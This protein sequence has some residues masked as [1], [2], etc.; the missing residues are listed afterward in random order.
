[1]KRYVE[2]LDSANLFG[3]KI[4][5]IKKKTTELYYILDKLETNRST[6]QT[7][8]NVTVYVLK[9]NKV[10][11]SSF[12]IYPYMDNREIKRKIETNMLNASF[13]LNEYYAIEKN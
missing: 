11:A 12:D 1:M 13:A 7:L 2:L 4:R 9:D 10:G 6:E 8:Y 5:E 3:W